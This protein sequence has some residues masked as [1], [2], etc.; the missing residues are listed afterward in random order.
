MKTRA[1]FV[2]IISILL[3]IAIGFITANQIHHSRFKE[4][5][6]MSSSDSFKERTFNIIHPSET[7][8][9]E[10]N[11]IVDKYGQIFDSLRKQTYCQFRDLFE[12]YHQ[13]MGPF[14]N[15]DQIKA[16]EESSKHFKREHKEEEEK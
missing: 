1:S 10:L 4:V 6:S 9:E 2:V 16:V 11:P 14:L 3:G 8:I 5:K 7:Q 13:T 15:E 12:E